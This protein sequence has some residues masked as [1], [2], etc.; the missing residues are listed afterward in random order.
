MALAV[1]NLPTSAGDARHADLIPGSG[2]A[3]EEGNGTLPQYSC[4]ENTMDRGAWQDTVP[5][6]AESDMTEQLSAHTVWQQPP[7]IE[8]SGAAA[9]DHILTFTK[10]ELALQQAVEPRA[11]LRF[12]LGALLGH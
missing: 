4:L 2:R 10:C 9:W 1:K 3:P 6:A 11:Q 5:G 7:Q 8:S 12:P